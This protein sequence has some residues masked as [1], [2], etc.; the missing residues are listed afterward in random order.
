MEM[1]ELA[2]LLKRRDVKAKLVAGY[3][4][5]PLSIGVTEDNGA[6]A[7]RVRVAEHLPDPVHTSVEVDGRRIPVIV[8]GSL[9]RMRAQ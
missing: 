3:E 2:R 5:P 6:W 4:V 1:Q 9:R 8:E 7:F